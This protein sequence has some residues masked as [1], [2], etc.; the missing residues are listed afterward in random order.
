MDVP[1]PAQAEVVERIRAKYPELTASQNRVADY[2]LKHPEEAVILSSTRLAEKV[3]VSQ[4]TVV[5]LTYFLGYESFKGLQRALQAQL[6]LRLDSVAR[7]QFSIAQADEDAP[8]VHKAMQGDVE[9]IV[10]TMQ[11]VP[12]ALIDKVIDEIIDARRI[13]LIGSGASSIASSFL[14]LGLRCLRFDTLDLL[15]AGSE[16][17]EQVLG[18]QARDALIAYSYARYARSTITCA[19]FARKMGARVIAFTDSPVSPLA[20]L[21]DTVVVTTP[22]PA[23]YLGAPVAQVSLGGAILAGLVGRRRLKI[24]ERLS[25]T[26]MTFDFFNTFVSSPNGKEQEN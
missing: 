19:E 24:E 11:M 26:E 14:G 13:Y 22:F 21:A 20:Q 25:N 2:I 6:A 16:M 9:A 23:W 3:G 8:V 17:A 10:R 12:V 4:S 5:R 15:Q 7:M 18:M 1:P